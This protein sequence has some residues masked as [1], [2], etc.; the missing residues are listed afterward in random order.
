[1]IIYNPKAQPQMARRFGDPPSQRPSR[2]PRAPH[3]DQVCHALNPQPLF[4]VYG[5]G[6]IFGKGS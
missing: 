3:R 4:I 2:T 1:M 5:T 6:K